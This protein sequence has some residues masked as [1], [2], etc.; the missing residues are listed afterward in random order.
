MTAP[1]H[2]VGMGSGDGYGLRIAQANAGQEQTLAQIAIDGRDQRHLQAAAEIQGGTA[3]N[4]EMQFEGGIRLPA[5][6]LALGQHRRQW[7]QGIVRG[8]VST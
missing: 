1:I 8:D 6:G 4:G 3:A 7:R 2:F 5:P